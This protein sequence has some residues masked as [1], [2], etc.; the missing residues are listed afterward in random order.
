MLMTRAYYYSKVCIH[1]QV[2]PCC[3]SGSQVSWLLIAHFLSS[4][5]FRAI[6]LFHVILVS[7]FLYFGL[8][9]T[10][11]L[12]LVSCL[13]HTLQQHTKVWLFSKMIHWTNRQQ[14]CMIQIYQKLEMEIMER[15]AATMLLWWSIQFWY[16]QCKTW[17]FFFL[18][19]SCYYLRYTASSQQS[20]SHIIFFS[21]G[22]AKG[23]P[24]WAS[25]TRFISALALNSK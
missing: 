5:Y 3:L 10:S 19:C 9:L 11:C 20:I 18:D 8:I 1:F 12:I 16:T 15:F 7:D 17:W 25:S 22:V 24:P 4:Y 13:Q 21:V 2:S 14:I 6:V 23:L